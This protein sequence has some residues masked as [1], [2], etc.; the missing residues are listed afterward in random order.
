K[1][2]KVNYVRRSQGDMRAVASL[3]LE[4]I[5]LMHDTEKGEVLVP[6]QVTD[7]SGEAPIECEMLWAWIPK[8]RPEQGAAA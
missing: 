6:V 7:E 8:K 4:Q 2:M 5:Q 1:S 3:S